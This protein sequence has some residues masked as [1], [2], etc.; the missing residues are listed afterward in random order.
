M[1]L[2]RAAQFWTN[3]RRKQGSRFTHVSVVRWSPMRMASKKPMTKYRCC[4]DRQ[5]RPERRGV[6][7]S[8]VSLVRCAQVRVMTR[9]RTAHFELYSRVLQ[10]LAV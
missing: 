1:G 5:L 2:T 4:C 7:E 9:R 8:I 10:K 3:P 6:L